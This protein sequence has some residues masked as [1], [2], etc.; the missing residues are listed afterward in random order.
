MSTIHYFPRYSQKENMVTNNTM[1][2]FKRLYNNS[3]DKFNRFLNSILEDSGIE[4]DISIKFGQQE[5]GQYSVPDAFIQQDSFKILIETKLYS[6]QNI[7]QIKGHFNEFKDEPN[8]IFLW[9][10]KESIATKYKN[11]IIDEVK[12]F[13]SK[14]KN[15]I[16]FASTTFKE[17]CEKFD[18]IL[19]DYDF[20]MKEMIQD[21]DAFCYESGLLDNAE[22]KIRLVP[23]GVTLDENLMYNIY[24]DPSSHSYQSHN[25]IGLYKD[26]TVKAV[27]KIIC[28]ADVNYD[29]ANDKMDVIETQIGTLTSENK[30]TIKKVM[31]HAYNEYGYELY[32]GHRFFIVDKF[33]ETDFKKTSPGGMMGKR[34]YDVSTI[35]GY[36]KGMSTKELA[37]LL[38]GKTWD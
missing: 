17:I 22:S 34:Y 31:T 6:Q 3:P 25:Y 11:Q 7:G 10:N 19:N 9:I 29:A 26:K 1:L 16:S 36:K 24:Y 18:D 12:K 23:V 8:Q 2:L 27:G 30:E 28:T 4:L 21:Y 32:E 5:R 13:N 20:E 38:R 15:K 33:Y 14:R 37:D 35:Q